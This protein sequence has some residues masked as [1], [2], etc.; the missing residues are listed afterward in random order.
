VRRIELV[1]SILLDNTQLSTTLA[2]ND[3]VAINALHP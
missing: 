2:G 1:S 3:G